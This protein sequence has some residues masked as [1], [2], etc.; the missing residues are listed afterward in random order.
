MGTRIEIA[1]QRGRRRAMM[2]RMA[3]KDGRWLA[4]IPVVV[5]VLLAALVFPHDADPNDVPLP[6]VD[7]KLVA[8]AEHKDDSLAAEALHAPLPGEV[9]ALGEGIRS[10][11]TAEAKNAP[12]T[13]WA[14]I[15]SS[16]DEARHL[17]LMK[18]IDVII[19]LR[20]TQLAKFMA[21]LEAWRRTGKETDELQAVGG[22]FVRRMTIEGW[23]DQDRLILND[24]EV[25]VAF[26][27]KWNAVARFE[28]VPALQPS[29]DE[30]RTLYRFYLLH[31][32]AGAGA[33]EAHV[34]ARLNARSR[35]DCDALAAGEQ[36]AIE[37]WRLEKIEK[38]AELDPSY[39]AAY[40][41]GVS[42][43][44][45]ARY[46]QAVWAFQEWLR[47]HPDGPLTLRARN[48]LHA[49]FVRTR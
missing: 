39:P 37:Q 4:L 11:N 44:R 24:H 6:D 3:S 8:V 13:H 5:G 18:G 34:A 22:G 29:F 17:A 33:R 21:E 45:A 43:F 42:L 16:L 10:F 14:T 12:D 49:S 46:E 7:E 26:K 41:R 35:A 9:R 38:L 30:L 1:A 2:W 31:P 19:Q 25:R 15:R 27:L 20:A 23:I 40:A 32:H 48:H 47:T 28:D 36:I